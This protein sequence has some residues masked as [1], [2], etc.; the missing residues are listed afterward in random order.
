MLACVRVRKG[1]SWKRGRARV[2]A[3]V[4]ACL[5]VDAPAAFDVVAPL[6]P[7]HCPPRSEVVTRVQ[8]W[9]YIIST[10]A[11]MVYTYIKVKQIAA[12]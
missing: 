3:S 1:S 5:L 9:G 7:P 4:R 12:G 11:F 2:H 6:E 10:A 8:A